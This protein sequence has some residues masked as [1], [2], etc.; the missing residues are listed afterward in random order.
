MTNDALLP[1]AEL[2]TARRRLRS[3]RVPVLIVA[4]AAVLVIT[5]LLNMAVEDVPILALLMG[6]GTAAAAIACYA[7]LSRKVE[8]RT[9]IT[10]LPRA[11][12]WSSLVKG[13]GLGFAAFTVGITLIGILGG[14][15]VGWGSFGALVGGFGAMASVAVNEELLFRGVVFRILSERANI[16]V[17]FVLSCLIFGFAHAVNAN[18]SLLG[19][20]SIAIQGGSL[21]ASAYLASRSLWLPIA[22]HCAWD[23]AEGNFFGVQN[24]GTE[25]TGLLHT[26]LTGPDWLT[27]GS[28]GPEA[29]PV[30]WV[31]CLSLSA[32]LLLRARRNRAQA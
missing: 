16:V 29:S 1:A 23:V 7:W 21:M 24:S 26:V 20:L 6:L 12:R 10:E 25:Q 30:T 8:A 9:S 3:F 19:L 17:A 14:W 13:F 28:F 5:R 11:G 31:V 4:M 15:S 27:G 32:V 22:I 18:A 2:S